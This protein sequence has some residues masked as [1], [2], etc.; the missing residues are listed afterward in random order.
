MVRVILGKDFICSKLT[1]AQHA[2]HQHCNADKVE[3]MYHEVDG[4]VYHRYD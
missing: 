4:R 3:F 1:D 2:N